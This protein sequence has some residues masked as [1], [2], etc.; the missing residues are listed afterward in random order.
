MTP[1]MMLRFF[2]NDGATTPATAEYVEVAEDGAI[3]GWRGVAPVVGW[4]QGRLSDT[5]WDA[6]GA[7]IARVGAVDP[8]PPPPGAATETLE[9]PGRDPVVVSGVGSDG[10]LGG[11]VSDARRLLDVTMLNRPR[12]AVALEVGRSARLVHRGRDPLT[13]D[14][15]AVTV[16]AHHWRGYYEPAGSATE[17]LTGDRVEAG[18]GW[19]LDLP[20]I[21]APAGPDITTHLTVDLGIVSGDTVV[22]VQA[23]HLPEIAQ[24][25]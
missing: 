12:A 11:L 25:A 5:A 2:R 6:L 24:P 4:F 19:T 7:H 1:R 3:T 21:T 10:P 8:G 16:Q 14:L 18:P 23:Q 17:V 13:L 20:A 9:L 15:A 22:P